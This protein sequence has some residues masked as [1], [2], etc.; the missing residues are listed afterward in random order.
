MIGGCARLPSFL[1]V[2]LLWSGGVAV[3]LFNLG[4]PLGWVLLLLLLIS[5]PVL[6]PQWV[7]SRQFG[8]LLFLGPL[9]AL[10]GCLILLA[11]AGATHHQLR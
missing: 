2:M 1:L 11:L 8:W 6:I 9:L 3:L 5:L 7:F 10:V 4:L